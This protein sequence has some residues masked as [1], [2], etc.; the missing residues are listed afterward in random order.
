M[1]LVKMNEKS[2]INKSLYD[3]MTNI[4]KKDNID[5]QSIKYY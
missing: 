2:R 5:S 1:L 3:V 4:Q